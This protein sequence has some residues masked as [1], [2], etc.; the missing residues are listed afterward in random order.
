VRGLLIG[1]RSGLDIGL[2]EQIGVV[3]LGGGSE[4]WSRGE[5]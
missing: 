2:E 5:G 3:D 4:G 1:W